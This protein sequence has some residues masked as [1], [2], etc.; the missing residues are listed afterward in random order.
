MERFREKILRDNEMEKIQFEIL[1]CTP[2]RFGKTTAVSMWCAAMLACVPDMWISV[3]STGQRAS[4][5]LLDQTAKFFRM[6]EFSDTCRGGDEMVSFRWIE[7]NRI[8]RREWFNSHSHGSQILRKNQEQLWTKGT[9][10]DD[11]R[12]MFSYPSSISGLKGDCIACIAGY[13]SLLK[14]TQGLTMNLFFGD[15]GVGGKV[16]YHKKSGPATHARHCFAA[17]A[18]SGS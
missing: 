3:F 13:N 18:Y 17:S 12:K 10:P 16:R 6:L 14:Q 1:V 7:R 5:S 9:R 2:R 11:I 4:S 8:F 15:A